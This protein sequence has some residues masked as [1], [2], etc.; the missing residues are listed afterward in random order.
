[1]GPNILIVDDVQ[2]A[3]KVVA[4]LLRRLGYTQLSEAANGE[5]ALALI[6]LSHFDVIISDWRMPKMDGLEFLTQLR[7]SGGVSRNS[8]FL[9]VTSS[10]DKSDVVTAIKAGVSDYICK[11]FTM[12]TLQGKLDKMLVQTSDES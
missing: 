8:P 11:P 12:E 7:Q 9:I 3:R 6:R 4:N 5:A 10:T 2:S 1:M